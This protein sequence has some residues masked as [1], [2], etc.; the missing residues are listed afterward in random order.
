[1]PVTAGVFSDEHAGFFVGGDKAGML[2]GR[3]ARGAKGAVWRRSDPGPID[4]RYVR[5]PPLLVV[6]VEGREEGEAALCVK[7]RWYF[8][9]GVGVVWLVL[10]STRDVLVLRHGGETRHAV[11]ERLP[12]D[13]ELPGLAPA[14]EGLFR[15]L[16]PR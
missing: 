10:P 5:V 14:V 8:A 1:M 2:F 15:Q 12:E 7:A 6:E 9:H 13:P 4:R 16:A 11:G 3:E